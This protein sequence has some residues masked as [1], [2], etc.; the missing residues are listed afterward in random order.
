MTGQRL[1]ELFAKYKFT[2]L[3][4][5]SMVRAIETADLIRNELHTCKDKLPVAQDVLLCEGAPVPPE[6]PVGH[7]KPEHYVSFTHLHSFLS[8][9]RNF[10]N[11]YFII[12]FLL[13]F[14]LLFSSSSQTVAA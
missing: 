11:V 2:K 1:N 12:D 8:S 7:W 5:S 14:L 3:H 6:P 13:L 10:K 9:F 4:H